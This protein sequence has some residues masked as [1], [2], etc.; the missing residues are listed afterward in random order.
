MDS[1][2]LQLHRQLKRFVMSK[3]HNVHDAEDIVQDVFIK[4]QL[5]G[6]QL[7]DAGKVTQWM[8]QITRNSIMDYFR[9]KKKIIEEDLTQIEEA[10]NEF[11]DCVSTCIIQLMQTLPGPYREALELVETKMI[12]QTIAARQLGISYSGLKSRVQRGRQMLKEKMIEYYRVQ[13]DGYG[14]VI[15]CE[16]ELPCG[17]SLPQD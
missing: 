2:T 8:F 14:N 11:N 17:C 7:H 5:K 1:T 3:V 6:S 15:A 4:A 9:E 16:N 10:Y 12:S 13:T